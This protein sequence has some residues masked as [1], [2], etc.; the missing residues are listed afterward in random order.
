MET[1]AIGPT[2]LLV[3]DDEAVLQIGSRMLTKLG[4]R[5]LT[6]DTGDAAVDLLVRHAGEVPLVVFDYSMPGAFCWPAATAGTRVSRPF[7]TAAATASSR[8]P[9]AW[10]S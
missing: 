3:D 4:L 10:T 6:A 5:I 9:S 2:V 1:D 7:L 8:N